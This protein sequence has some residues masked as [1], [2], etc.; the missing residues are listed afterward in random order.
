MERTSSQTRI[1]ATR[2]LSLAGDDLG[3]S[4]RSRR[5]CPRS[6][7]FHRLSGR[8]SRREQDG[9]LRTFFWFGPYI[10]RAF[11]GVDDL[12]YQREPQAGAA[13]EFGLKRLKD[14]V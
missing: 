7:C 14:L 8:L 13:L 4:S 11:M 2:H 6:G 1:L 10:N 9:E 5:E 3:P 12:I